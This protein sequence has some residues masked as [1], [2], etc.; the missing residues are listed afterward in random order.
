MHMHEMVSKP[1]PD[2]SDPFALLDTKLTSFNLTFK[3]SKCRLTDWYVYIIK[4]QQHRV[5]QI[6]NVG[7]ESTVLGNKNFHSYFL[8]S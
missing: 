6:I 7:A 2:S 1:S 4:H 3:K 8:L 5:P